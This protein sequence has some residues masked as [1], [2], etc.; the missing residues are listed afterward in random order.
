RSKQAGDEVSLG[1]IHRGEQKTVKAKLEPL[2]GRGQ[3]RGGRRAFT[4]DRNRDNERNG[5]SDHW[6]IFD[7]MT[8]TQVDKNKFK[9]EIAYRDKDG[10]VE[11]RQFEGTRDELRRDIEQQKDL[12]ASE[13]EHLLS[14]LGL[15]QNDMDDFFPFWGPDPR[16]FNMPPR[17]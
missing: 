8:I 1:V 14:A 16:W 6:N 17:Y 7:S 10:K 13:R 3:P 11:K 9:A 2:P 4:L 12:P 5:D 15:G